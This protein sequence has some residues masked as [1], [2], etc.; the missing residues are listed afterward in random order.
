MI[1][2][3]KLSGLD[4]STEFPVDRHFLHLLFNTKIISKLKKLLDNGV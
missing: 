4:K 1:T 2:L 3:T